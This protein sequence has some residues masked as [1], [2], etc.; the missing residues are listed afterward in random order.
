[1]QSTQ[2]TPAQP[3]YP[4]NLRLSEPQPTVTALGTIALLQRQK[5]GLIASAQCPETLGAAL[6]KQLHDLC[7]EIAIVSGFHSPLEQECLTILLAKGQPTI[8]CVAHG[9]AKL[10]LSDLERHGLER[11]HHLLLSPFSAS[12][13]RADK[14]LAARRNRFVGAIADQVLIPYAAPGSK[15]EA[16]ARA[17]IQQNKP[18]LTVMHPDTQNLIDMG[19]TLLLDRSSF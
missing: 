2:L 3:H 9:L 17:I 7:G 13:K 8:R 4:Q 18:L 15:T 6:L 12:I 10:S 11:G 19:A 16:I 5:I 14:A 1:M